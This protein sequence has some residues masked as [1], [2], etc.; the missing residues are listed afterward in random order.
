MDNSAGC[1]KGPPLSSY[2][3]R[4]L[5]NESWW[6]ERLSAK[7]NTSSPDPFGSTWSTVK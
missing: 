1:G 6:L 2:K 3:E 5:V 4:N 7:Q